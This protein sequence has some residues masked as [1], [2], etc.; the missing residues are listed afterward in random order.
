MSENKPK[1]SLLE[2]LAF[3]YA[4]V[5]IFGFGIIIGVWIVTA[6]GSASWLAQACWAGL[7]LQ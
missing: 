7:K 2:A 1:K 4:P 5:T 6:L 3:L